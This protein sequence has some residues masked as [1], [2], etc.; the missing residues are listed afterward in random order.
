M[1]HG[2]ASRLNGRWIGERSCSTALSELNLCIYIPMHLCTYVPRDGQ[3]RSGICVYLWPVLGWCVAGQG[4]KEALFKKGEQDSDDHPHLSHP[5]GK[6]PANHIR[7][8]CLD[9]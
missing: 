4:I 8:G 3:M 9:F 5:E 7:L 1:D 6:H 2:K